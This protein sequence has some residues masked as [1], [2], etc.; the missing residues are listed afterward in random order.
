MA[1]VE[2]LADCRLTEGGQEALQIPGGAQTP[3]DILAYLMSRRLAYAPHERDMVLLHHSFGFTAPGQDASGAEKKVTASL[4]HY[5]DDKASAMSVT[6]G[7]TLAFAAGRVL[8]GEVRERG[9]TGPYAREVW[10]GTLE[11]L[12]EAGVRVEE[13]WA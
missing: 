11:R 1:A 5:G 2:V 4:V 6:V 7:K 8:D 12:E 13:W 3:I 10:E 9:V